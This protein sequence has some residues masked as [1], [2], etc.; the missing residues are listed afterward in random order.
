MHSCY[1][2]IASK[3]GDRPRGSRRGNHPSPSC[4]G[5]G[6]PAA[7]LQGQRLRLARK[8]LVPTETSPAGIGNACRGGTCLQGRHLWALSLQ[9]LLPE[10]SGA[11]LPNGAPAPIRGGDSGTR[12]VVAGD[13]DA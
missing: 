7:R 10:S 4:K 2:F 3:G 13:Y 5:W 1:V 8:E 9:E 12:D 11:R 6:L